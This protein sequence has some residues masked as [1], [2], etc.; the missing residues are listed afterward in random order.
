MERIPLYEPYL[1]ALAD[2]FYPQRCVGCGRRARDV[3]CRA[4]FEALP[5][6]GHPIC[7]R[8]GLPTAF[9]T[10]VCEECKNV[11]FNFDSARAPLRYEGVG[12]KVVHALKYRGYTRVVERLAAPLIVGVLGDGARFDAVVPVPLHRSRLRKRGFNQAE[13]LAGG[14]AR[15]INAPLSDT[16]EVVRS[17]RDQVELSAA[18][19][20][21]NVAGAFAARGRVAGRILLVDDVFTTGATMSA[22]A[23][24]LLGAG[25]GEV[26][27]LSLCRTV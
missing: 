22:C 26:H 27:A 3:L 19:R 16:L 21:A 8:C 14:V 12:K 18:G 7:A 1:A 4:C 5:E 23:G 25:A 17:T 13:L 11:D 9:E 10:L 24:T 15:K 6:V 20:R 2:L